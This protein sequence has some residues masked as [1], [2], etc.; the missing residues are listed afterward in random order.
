MIKSQSNGPQTR[1]LPATAAG[2]GV[3]D[4]SLGSLQSGAGARFLIAARPQVV[5]GFSSALR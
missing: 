5:K 1:L 2:N 3:G 4:L